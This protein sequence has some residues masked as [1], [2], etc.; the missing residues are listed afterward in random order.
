[1][2]SYFKQLKRVTPILCMGLLLVLAVIFLYGQ[3]KGDDSPTVTTGSV[4]EDTTEPSQPYTV[5]HFVYDDINLPD[6]I[7]QAKVIYCCYRDED[8]FIL[9]IGEPNGQEIGQCCRTTSFAVCDL[10]G[11]LEVIPVSTEADILTALPYKDGILFADYVTN[12]DETVDWSIVYQTEGE[13]R[14]LDS[15]TANYYDSSPYLFLVDGMPCYMWAGDGYFAA[16]CIQDEKPEWILKREDCLL[17]SVYAQSAGFFYCYR[18]RYP[19]NEHETLCLA[20]LAG[21]SLELDIPGRLYS[22][23]LTGDYLIY[24]AGKEGSNLCTI[25]VVDTTNGQEKDIPELVNPMWQLCGKGDGAVAVGGSWRAYWIDLS[26]GKVTR[27]P[28]RGK[29][30]RYFSMDE[31]KY[32]VISEGQN[33]YRFSVMSVE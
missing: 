2:F 26:W 18:I 31:R 25:H 10:N 16:K 23:T 30:E 6:S 20:N 7:T 8:G 27:I 24:I 29:Q 21:M 13:S 28:G 33:G 1:M 3:Q 17:S 11:N 22:Y 4:T 9:S 19:D 14:I 15:G 32:F 5:P 12:T